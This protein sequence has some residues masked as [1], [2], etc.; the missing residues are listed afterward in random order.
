M[1]DTSAAVGT[2]PDRSQ[3]GGTSAPNRSSGS[4]SRPLRGR[5]SPRHLHKRDRPPGRHLAALPLPALPDQAGA[6]P[7]LARLRS[8]TSRRAAQIR[9]S[10]QRRPGPEWPA[11]CSIH[12]K[13]AAREAWAALLRVALCDSDGVRVRCRQDLTRAYAK[14][15][16]RQLCGASAGR[17]L[18]AFP[19]GS[20]RRSRGRVTRLAL[21]GKEAVSYSVPRPSAVA[22]CG[23]GDV[24]FPDG[25]PPASRWFGRA[26]AQAA[27][28]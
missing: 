22:A 23:V 21:E 12:R 9:P 7:G 11:E 3:V 28:R 26:R 1:S 20:A 25:R 17:P 2:S 14:H 16:V 5:R 24:S 18:C 10:R 19:I 13:G 8:S 27:R 15:P 4:R 6:V